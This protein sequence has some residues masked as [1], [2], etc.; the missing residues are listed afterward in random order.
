V[1]SADLPR[2]TVL[3]I[4]HDGGEF[5]LP[6]VESVVQQD[7]PADRLEVLLIDNA[8][9]DG[10]VEAVE[11]RFPAVRVVRNATND[12]FAPVVNQGARLAKGEY[13]ALLNNDAVADRR[14]LRELVAPML[15]DERI[16]VT[17]GLLLDD[18][19][20]VVDFAGGQ[21][22]FYGQGFIPWRGEPVPERLHRRP[23]IFVCGASMAMPTDWFLDVGG[24]DEDFFAFVEDVDFG[25]RTWVLGHECWFI[26]EAVAHHRHHGTI[27]RFGRP[28]EQYL[29][30]RNALASV[31][32]NFDDENLARVLPGSML[33]SLLR[34]F[35]DERSELGD[36]RITAASKGTPPPT[37][38]VSDL[39]GAHLAAVRDFGLMLEGLRQKRAYIQQN[40]GRSDDDVIALFQEP[41]AANVLDRVFTPA[42]NNVIDAFDLS[43]PSVPRKT[44]L[45][46]TADPISEKMAGPAIRVWEMARLLSAEHDV[47]VATVQPPEKVDPVIEVVHL[48]GATVGRLVERAHVIV[49]GGFLLYL[50]P[51]IAAS[52]KP[53]V[54]DVYD[55]FHI[56]AL[57]QRK[58]EPADERWAT[59][60]SDAEVVNDQ[61]LRGDLLLCASEKQRDFWLGQLAA[62]KRI[63]PATYDDDPDLRRLLDVAPFGLPSE[64]PVQRRRAIR[65]AGLGV[66]DDDVVL[67]WG[68]GIYNWFDPSTLLRG[69]RKAVDVDP[70]LKLYFLG[71]AHPNPFVPEM[72]RTAEARRVAEELGLLG[73]HVLFNDG[74]VD[75][76]QRADWLLDAD[77]GVSTH[78]PHVETQLSFRTRVL[79]YLW[80]GLPIVTTGGDLLSELIEREGLGVVVPAEDPDA[81]AAALLRLADPEERRAMQARIREIAPTMTWEAALEPLLRFCRFPRRA[82]DLVSA[83]ARPHLVRR[84]PGRISGRDPRELVRRFRSRV[85]QEGLGPAV[86]VA[87]NY[88][89]VQWQIRRPL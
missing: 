24:F 52:D 22:A 72:A 69:L 71:T 73:T 58:D 82:P 26:P 20:Q 41:R 3:L 28:R 76:A 62:L 44:V 18:T 6:A 39:T 53:V 57:V 7:Y 74:W 48:T 87:Q 80:A 85:R 89:R 45:L 67:L 78:F 63:N 33:L 47:V 55:P 66:E 51:Q 4:N 40:R 35:A 34:G 13:L 15:V 77:V 49:A 27:Q 31:F 83:R 79:D 56:E 1:A 81:I 29:I 21:L 42:F 10:S 86:R 5:L 19:G 54:V 14:W 11:A 43:W 12:G 25:W 2:A 84:A 8:S 30:E 88:L 50:F 46:V 16:K 32:K 75:Y 37:P 59:A 60:A 17:G 9:T 64:P 61:L 23:S 68:G 65:D 38:V 36:Y 70:R